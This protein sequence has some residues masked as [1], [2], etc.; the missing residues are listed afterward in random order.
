MKLL[1]TIFILF[2]FMILLSGI[3]FSKDLSAKDLSEG[4]YAQFNTTKGKITARLY[5]QQVPLTVINFAGLAQGTKDSNQ[6][7]KK[8]YYD[9][10]IFH[11]VIKNFMIQGGDP[12]GTGMG[13]PGYKFPDEFNDNLKHDS[14][15][16]LS[17]ANAGPGT[18]GSQFFITH[19]ST[20]HLNNI[21]TVFGKVIKGMDV[22][23]K[24]EQ[25]DRIIT[26]RIVRVGKEAEAFKADQASFNAEL[27]KVEF[28]E[29]MEQKGII[30]KFETKMKNKYPEA[31]TTQSG[32]MYVI[33]EK[34]AGENPLKGAQVKVH[35]TG[36][37]LDGKVFDSSVERNSP[38]E[39]TLGVGKV[40]KGWDQ[41][42][43]TMKKGEK[44]ILLIPHWLAYGKNG[45]PG[46]IPPESHLIFD[47][48]LIEFQ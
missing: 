10:L 16:I 33:K 45:Y 7:P 39:F 30:S 25:G 40:I 28:K 3:S 11:R 35:Y 26:L 15:G 13:G 36:K 29:K 46:A 1:K 14:P 44:R 48:E 47:V 24:I 21:H 17:M 32:L 37:F 38:I 4:L 19:T 9:G 27:Y 34:G 8:K 23:N 2:S 5:Y 22:V 18:N 6:A 41:A 31:I 43:L 42:I 12:I 20:P